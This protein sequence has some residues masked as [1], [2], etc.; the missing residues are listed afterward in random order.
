MKKKR[1]KLMGNSFSVIKQSQ[2]IKMGKLLKRWKMINKDKIK[3]MN[4]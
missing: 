1:V 4:G 2:L 3:V